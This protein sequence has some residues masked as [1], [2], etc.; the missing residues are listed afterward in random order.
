M[1]LVRDNELFQWSVLLLET[2]GQLNSLVKEHVAVVVSMDEQ[3]RRC[4][5]RDIGIGGCGKG[6]GHCAFP[7]FVRFVPM[8]GKRTTLGELWNPVRNAVKID[9]GLEDIRV[10]RE[11]ET[12]EISAIRAAVDTDTVTIGSFHML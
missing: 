11:P 12:G 1:N 5:L 9:A 3:H 6:G 7:I 2:V 4:P 8:L 10:S